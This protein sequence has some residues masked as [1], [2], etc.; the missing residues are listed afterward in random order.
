MAIQA[1]MASLRQRN[2][3]LGRRPAAPRHQGLTA[4]YEGGSLCGARLGWQ[5]T[6]AHPLPAALLPASSENVPEKSCRL[7]R[8][9]YSK[10]IPKD[11]FHNPT[12]L[13]LLLLLASHIRR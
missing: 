12:N 3:A 11:S 1:E 2:H 5:R 8:V 13:F 6:A 9:S 10:G 4:Q 7:Q